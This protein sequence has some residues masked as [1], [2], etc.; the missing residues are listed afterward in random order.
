MHWTHLKGKVT[1]SLFLCIMLIAAGTFL[2]GCTSTKYKAYSGTSGHNALKKGDFETALVQYQEALRICEKDNCKRGVVVNLI[3]MGC[4][5]GGLGEVSE[6]LDNFKKGLDLAYEINYEE[7]ILYAVLNIAITSAD[8][9]DFKT[10]AEYLEKL[11]IEKLPK[12]IR[13]SFLRIRGAICINQGK[14]EEGLKYEIES[15][16]MCDSK[17]NMDNFHKVSAMKNIAGAF[18]KKGDYRK[19]CQYANDSLT[20]LN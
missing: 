4:A 2:S 12:K 9:G 8:I 17:T 20:L 3:N 14:Y 5:Y 15:L 11:D 19:A 7:Q 1:H 6:E 16:K 10:A 13:R 18:L